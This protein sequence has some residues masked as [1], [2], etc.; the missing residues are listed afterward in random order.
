VYHAVCSVIGSVKTEMRKK[1]KV[2]VD[3]KSVCISAAGIIFYF[4]PKFSYNN[5]C[6]VD[7]VGAYI[8]PLSPPA[9]EETGS[10]CRAIESAVVCIGW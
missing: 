9:T 5:P 1:T 10:M 2:K 6:R 7:Y 4:C 8:V 3:E